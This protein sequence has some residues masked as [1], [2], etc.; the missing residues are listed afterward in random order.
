MIRPIRVL[1]LLILL[2]VSSPARVRAADELVKE[3]PAEVRRG[4]VVAVDPLAARVGAEIL[5]RGGNAIDAAVATSFALSVTYPEAGNI[6]GGGFMVVRMA[7]KGEAFCVDY[8]ET[9]PRLATPRMFLDA[10]GN[11]DPA[12]VHIGWL[13]VGTPGTVHGLWTAHQ[14]A[15]RLPWRELV[16]PAVKLAAAGFVVEA[17]LAESLAEQQAIFRQMGEPARVYF[18]AGE[19]PK[20]GS[21][22]KLPELAH[23][24]ALIRDEGATGF[25]MGENAERIERAMLANGGLVR[26]S[27]LADYRAVIRQPVRGTYRGHE[28]IGMPPPSSGG[29]T[30]INMLNLLEGFDLRQMGHNTPETIHTMAEAMRLAYYDRARYL[31]DPDFVEMPLDRL[32]SK[33]YAT[34]RRAMIGPRAGNSHRLGAEILTPPQ[35]EQTT[36]FSIIDA[37]G[38]MVS[39]TTTLEGEF[40]AKVIAPGTGFLLNNEMHD[41]NVKPGLTN[42]QGLIGTPP[43]LIEP[44]K[45]MLSS[46]SPILVVKEGRPRLITGSPGGRTIINTVLQVTL[47]VIDHQLDIQAAVDAGRV[48]HQWLPDRLWL[49]ARIPPATAEALQQMGHTT[50]TRQAQGDAHSILI[51]AES[52]A[53]RPGVDHRRRGAAFG[54]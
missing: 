29:V 44:G 25:Y 3:N 53:Y 51:D 7:A 15:G 32:L 13:T 38:N 28:I 21:I 37:E 48:H 26:Q 41:F 24:L 18:P 46:M 17:H 54:F 8:R 30:L 2:Q 50:T 4:L 14:R 31:G 20:V 23:T 5:H 1:L 19:P 43:N 6:G 49:E 33:Q 42:D 34:G 45:R 9:A 16:D 35:S 12:K 11:I 39:N 40:G 52:G 47:N 10:R 36:H 27:D 22:L